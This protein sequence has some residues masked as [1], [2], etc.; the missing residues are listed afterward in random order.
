MYNNLLTFGDIIELD[1][2][3]DTSQLINNISKYEW[4]KYNPRKDINRYG[5]SVTSLDGKLTGIDLDSI[6]E[7]NKENNTSYN[8]VLLLKHLQRFITIV[9]KQE[10]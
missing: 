6:S 3:C 8:E 9:K 4:L 7:Y 10:N 5:L 2:S 1:L